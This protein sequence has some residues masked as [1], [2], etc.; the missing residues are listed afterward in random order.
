MK[1]QSTGRPYLIGTTVVM[2]LAIM[3][4]AIFTV[5]ELHKGVQSRIN[6]T[7]QNLAVSV[8]QTLD[9]LLDTIDLALLA[10]TDEVVRQSTSGH[11]N[12][13][14]ISLYMDQQ[15]MR[16]SHVAFMRGTNVNGD[17][18][19]GS[20]RPN[21]R[22]NLSERA[23]FIQL[24]DDPDAGLYVSKPV[25]GKITGNH[26]ITFA[27]RINQPDGSFAGTVY[28]SINVDDLTMLLAQIKMP[29]GGSI[30]LRAADQ[31]LMARHVFGGKNDIPIGSASL[32]PAFAET[33]QR[34]PQSGT[35][36][37][38]ANSLDPVIRTYSYQRSGKYKFL[39]IVGLPMEQ[40]FAEWR[41]QSMAVLALASMLSLALAFMVY[42]TIRA[43]ARL[44]AL[45]DSLE[46]SQTQLQQNH[47]QL[48]Q[49]EQHHLS[50]LQNLHTGVVVHAPDSS[51]VFSNTQA[52]TLLKLTKEQ[53]LGKTSVDPAWCFVDMLEVPLAPEEY[54][55]SKVIRDRRAFEGMELGVMAPGED[56]LIWL[57]VSAFPEFTADGKLKQVIVNFYEI[58]KR[59]QAEQARE[60]VTRALRLVTDTNITLARSTSKTQLLEDICALIC[61]KGG[62][63]M[64]WVGYAQQDGAQSVLPMA[65]A[66]F[67]EGYI[68]S[69]R[70]SWSETSEFGQGPTGLAI[71][72]GETQVNRDYT[73]NPAMLP[74]LQLAQEHGFH[75]SIA[76]PFR[77]KSGTQGVLTI[78]SARA[79]AFSD[80]EVVLLEELTGNMAHELD[81]LE[82]RRRRYEAESASK[83][84]ATFLSNMSHEIRTP[85]NAIVGMAHLIRRDGLTPRQ[86]DK[87]DKLEKASQHLLNIL[88]DILDL[89]KIDA[90]KLALEQAPLR[91]ESI[92][93]NVVSMVQQRAQGKSLALVT[94]VGPLPKNLEGDVTR[95]Q[96]AL[97]NY[98]INA[99]KFTEVGQVRIGAQL[100]EESADSALLRFEV[101]DT[102]IGIEPAVLARLF[103]DFEQADNST[104][105][106]FG[107]TGLGLSIT[108]KLARLMGGEAGA[109]STPGAGSNFWFTAHLKKGAMQPVRM[110]QQS[111]ADALAQLQTKHAGVRV[112]VAEDEPV[113]S[114]IACILLEDAGFAVDVA[115]D[116]ALALEKARQNSYGVILMDMQMP[117]MDGLEAT[118]KI[119]Q[120]PGYANTPILAMTA[121]AFAE[122]KARCLAAG[123]NA[124]ITKPVPPQELYVAL[125]QALA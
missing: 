61:E 109:S 15:V 39:A 33:L 69:V 14:A 87:L 9:G 57:E 10:A 27:R 86:S 20:G 113:N 115:E 121:N 82:D 122:D 120:L 40:S 48:N 107:G 91:V 123:M 68:E 6:S 99:I 31:S 4:A 35:Y 84:K 93:A 22:V 104:S 75:S 70:I 117:H 37:S 63:L 60:R 24:R 38:D 98:A 13:Q 28:A 101:S 25:I 8:Q 71:R 105:R 124:F 103:F 19:Y 23:F 41:R 21:T 62:Y 114:E 116:G 90:D 74:W 59:R 125:L 67:D 106:K 54:P 79:D 119:R 11:A 2:C 5:L 65:H 102:G 43:R 1:P 42:S 72:T 36:V 88:N 16:L 92:V 52:C 29:S 47:L 55:A 51:I 100:V 30:T 26:V 97:L 7:T 80:D 34:E 32:A 53:I 89:S 3:G 95:L 110:V 111:T 112:L 46:S 17:V 66:G 12:N 85:L 73:N 56:A 77:K 83:A 58:T 76:L 118:A 44:E 94:E 81:A 18:V 50:L 108:R 96:Q 49:T 78:Y 45:V 64:A